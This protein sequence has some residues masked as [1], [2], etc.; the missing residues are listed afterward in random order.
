[1]Y[2]LSPICILSLAAFVHGAAFNPLY[3]PKHT[4]VAS[5]TTNDP[6]AT[7]PIHKVHDARQ[8]FQ[9]ARRYMGQAHWLS[10]GTT[11]RLEHRQVPDPVVKSPTVVQPRNDSPTPA[12][13]GD[14]SPNTTVHI[15]DEKNF[16]LIAP[17]NPQGVSCLLHYQPHTK[18][19]RRV[20]L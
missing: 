6:Q 2:V 7:T 17:K 4:I 20:Y 1:M 9:G 3:N 16:A 11:N 8:D 10:S 18:Q 5:Q 12:P 13:T 19:F 15:S 14:P